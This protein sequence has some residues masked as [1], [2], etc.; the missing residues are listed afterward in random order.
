MTIRK[1]G[2]YWWMD[3]NL[4]CDGRSKRILRSC[5]TKNR[6]EAMERH[7]R[8][9]AELWREIVL[10]EQPARTWGEAV[11][12]YLSEKQDMRSLRADVAGKIRWLQARIP[13]D[14]PLTKIGRMVP[15]LRR[16]R[17]EQPGRNGQ[18]PK[19]ATV[20]ATMAILSAILNLAEKRGY[21]DRAPKID[22]P[23]P[24]NARTRWLTREEAARVLK[25]CRDLH[26]DEFGDLVEFS[27]ETGLRQ[28]NAVQLLPAWI[29]LENRSLT[30]PAEF[31]KTKRNFTLP[32]SDRAF[33]LVV[34]GLSR[35]AAFVFPS[36][37][38]KVQREVN[39]RLKAACAAVGVADFV[40]H[41]LRHTWA[42]WH[43]RAGTPI[44]VLMKLGGWVDLVMPLRYAALA[45]DHIAGWRNNAGAGLALPAAATA[46]TAGT[47]GTTA[48]TVATAGAELEG[49]AS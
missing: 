32:L 8:A 5:K 11:A 19:Q 38:G 49:V 1:R 16:Q 6:L 45:A 35:G 37:T 27:L 46:G 48:A 26:G 18:P 34:K 24:R 30:I 15:D 31:F 36:P 7:D 10:D 12:L 41:D 4:S 43:I 29:H 47:A 14:T 20:N 33:Q 25:A 39:E 17:T 22:L 42:T 9:R 28:Q 3:I 44:E 13:D 23:N 21:I 40:W 2:A